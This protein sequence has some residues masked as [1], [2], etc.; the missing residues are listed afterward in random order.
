[1]KHWIIAIS[2][3]IVYLAVSI[4]LNAWAWSWVIWFAYCAYRIID[5][6]KKQ[7]SKG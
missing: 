1:M 3:A 7:Q 5:N 6:K 4:P 2:V